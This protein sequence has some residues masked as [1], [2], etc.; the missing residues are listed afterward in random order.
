MPPTFRA[1]SA[2][3][4]VAAL[5][6][7]G[8]AEKPY[9]P[10][11]FTETGRTV[12][13]NIRVMDL[14]ETSIYPGLQANLWAFCVEAASAND[15]YSRNAITYW[16]PIP[17]WDPV[18]GKTSW[19]DERVTPRPTCS[20][21]A[22]TITV[23]QGDRVKVH[24]TNTHTKHPHTIHWH[25]Q[26]VDAG[27]DGVPGAS[28]SSVQP[29]ESFEYEFI[30]K[31]A[32]TLWYHCHVDTQMHVMQ[33]LF[34]MFVV[35]PQDTRFEP[36]V[37]REEALI[38]STAVRSAIEAVPGRFPHGHQSGEI[39]GEVGSRNPPRDPEPDVFMINGH[40]FPLTHLQ[41][42][43]S[44]HVAPGERVR[45]RVLNA[46][47]TV[48]TLHLHGHDMMVTHRDGSPLPG[49]PMFVDTLTIGPAE[50]Y[51]MVVEANNPGLWPIHTHVASHETNDRQSPGG[52]HALL[53]YH[54]YEESC[55]ECL[56][57]LPGGKAYEKPIFMPA[58]FA[59]ST[60]LPLNPSPTGVPA[61]GVAVRAEWG[62]PVALA[63]AVDALSLDAYLEGTP[64]GMAVSNVTVE[65]RDPNGTLVWSA[66]LGRG[67]TNHA[68]FQANGSAAGSA[69][70]QV[71]A[72]Q[73]KVAAYG[74]AA[75][76][77]VH[78]VVLVD[79]YTSFEEMQRLHDIDPGR[80]A[81]KCGK[82]GAGTQ[83]AE[84]PASPPT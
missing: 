46:G 27:M 19:G 58:D 62:F 40:S 33:G 20:V 3:L 2:L 83:D 61:R 82:Y 39:S 23:A 4:T 65:L 48:E 55:K 47:E 26:L 71:P 38:L 34:G 16:N 67:G 6:L 75:Q 64:V 37:D 35:K 5:A 54:G 77:S 15:E 73:W 11:A 41:N 10:D 49:G 63:C 1:A 59:N 66:A 13:L 24:F 72:G 84:P 76:V 60:I 30:A 52:M 31:K 29:G 9:D 74:W 7:A 43:T 56:V 50:R 69:I 18:D 42:Q 28:Q 80:Y 36:E 14:Y 70:P 17:G 12:E 53:V 57:E 45:F 44:V 81:V 78:L 51:D 79:Y 21:P 25:G 8:C 32:G 22:P 68:R